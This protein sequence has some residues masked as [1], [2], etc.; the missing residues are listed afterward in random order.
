MIKTSKLSK[1]YKI[2]RNN[3]FDALKSIDFEIENESMIAIMGESGSGKSTFMNLVSTLDKPNSGEVYFNDEKIKYNSEKKK[4]RYRSLNIGFVF[5]SF[6]L[7]SDIPIEDN[8][9][10]AMEIA[11]V[12]KSVRTKRAEELLTLVGLKD[13]IGKKPGFLSGGQKQRVAI[14]RALAN[15]PDLILADEPTGALDRSTSKDIMQL[16]K[17]ISLSGTKVLIVTHDKK[18]ASYCD[19]I[20]EMSD[21]EIIND[22]PNNA[23]QLDTIEIPS[24]VNMTSRGLGISG[25]Y[26]LSKSAFVRKLK[27]NLIVCISLAI[28]VSSILVT[29]I[30]TTSL[31]NYIDVLDSEYGNDR[32][33]NVSSFGVESDIIKDILDSVGL[34][35][36][37]VV[38]DYVDYYENRISNMQVVS[39]LE[40]PNALSVNNMYPSNFGTFTENDLM[41]GTSPVNDNEVVISK[42]TVE[43][44]GFEIDNSLSE[45]I[46]VYYI[47][48]ETS[49]PTMRTYTIVGVLSEDSILNDQFSNRVYITHN[50]YMSFATE[51]A[52]YETSTY[53]ITEGNRDSFIDKYQAEIDAEILN[54]DLDV[55]ISLNTD[56]NGI[57]EMKSMMDMIFVSFSFVLA[58]SIVVAMTMIAIMIYVSILERMKEIGVL[59]AIG[60]MKKDVRKIFYFEA[61]AIGLIGG[62]LSVVLGLSLSFI[63]VKIIGN[64]NLVSGDLTIVI[65]PYILV[66][67]LVS[68]IIISILSSLA[69]IALGLKVTPVEALRKR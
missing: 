4:S 54:R 45:E 3:Y 33:V 65:K 1:S 59:R 43:A 67:T 38:E 9:A 62:I 39:S 60:A 48:M 25:V 35:N 50:E 63:A 26:K 61:L 31:S 64:T 56:N 30:S 37:E 69:S 40:L 36:D 68:C 34:Q 13:H 41:L 12:S 24:K 47:D 28:A 66:I 21:G 19:R 6:N 16:L 55:R 5:Q 44:Y 18:V 53:L 58:I 51:D 10:I 57:A 46:S 7:V 49:I 27:R 11:G 17:S 32:V 23:E 2:S 15:N 14:A 52:L 8:V 22:T 42:N 20:V 29:S